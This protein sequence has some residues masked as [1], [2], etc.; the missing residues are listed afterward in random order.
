[1]GLASVAKCNP[2]PTGNHVGLCYC[3][4]GKYKK[5][6]NRRSRVYLSKR[7]Q[8]TSV[9]LHPTA[10]SHSHLKTPVTKLGGTMP[11]GLPLHHTH[12]FTCKIHH[13]CLK[14]SWEDM[15][16]HTPFFIWSSSPSTVSLRF[17]CTRHANELTPI[18]HPTG[19]LQAIHPCASQR[20]PSFFPG[21]CH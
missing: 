12:A 6:K 20:A 15:R 5:I 4:F 18:P 21:I 16:L 9:H 17:V 1:M 11:A 10:H 3:I 2:C 13:T 19:S 8:L 7:I 14:C